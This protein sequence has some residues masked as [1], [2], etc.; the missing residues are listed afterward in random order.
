M[1]GLALHFLCIAHK[2]KLVRKVRCVRFTENFDNVDETVELLPDSAKP[3]EPEMPNHGNED[4][5]V[6]RYPARDHVRPKYLDD[7]VTGEDIDDAI[8]DTANCT[9]DFCYRLANVPKSYQD[10]T[11]SPE[12]N[13]WR[14]AMSEELSA[15]WDNEP[16][17]SP[18]YQRVEHLWR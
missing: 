17:N 4:A 15:L 10:A 7:Y 11:S 9:I 12:A 1:T 13:K 2:Q 18:L 3:G 6:R 8:D 14:D 16:M 5:N